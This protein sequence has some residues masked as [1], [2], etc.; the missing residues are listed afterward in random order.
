[1]NALDGSHLL[2]FQVEYLFT[3]KTG[4]LTENDMQFRQCSVNGI[5]LV[6][7]GGVLCV[8]P[9]I[10]NVQP[11]PISTV[12]V[13]VLESVVAFTFNAE[14]RQ[15]SQFCSN[16]L[17]FSTNM[18]LVH[19]EC[20]ITFSVRL[21]REMLDVFNVLVLCHTCRVDRKDNVATGGYSETGFEYEYQA[22]SPDEKALVEAC[23]R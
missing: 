7:I 23:R 1:M 14:S 19:I 17:D 5:K 6:D 22:S 21:Q 2:I 11:A 9:D 13:S 18:I 10:P 15:I 12:T 8:Q 16:G 3:D 20:K 4:T